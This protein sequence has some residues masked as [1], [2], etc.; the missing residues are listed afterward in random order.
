MK[1]PILLCSLLILGLLETAS[2]QDVDLDRPMSAKMVAPADRT[3]HQ[4]NTSPT[5]D[6][7][8]ILLP[9]GPLLV[10]TEISINDRHHQ[11]IWNELLAELYRT[12]DTN[13]DG[14]VTWEEA[15][16]NPRFADGRL[17][18]F[19]Q[20]ED[21]RQRVVR[22]YDRNNN[23]KVDREEL[24]F[25]IGGQTGFT[26]NGSGRS[27]NAQPEL[28]EL[29]DTNQDGKLSA[30][31]LSRAAARLLS[32]DRNDNQI[33][34]LYELVSSRRTARRGQPAATSIR[35]TPSETDWSNVCKMLIQR[36]SQ[37]EG[38][39]STSHFRRSP[40]LA[41]HLDQN[42]NQKLE[43]SELFALATVEPHLVLGIRFSDQSA[44]SVEIVSTSSELADVWKR[45][46]H[47]EEGISIFLGDCQLDI[48]A[49]DR[50]VAI[51][52]NYTRQAEQIIQRFDKDKNQYLER[53][54]LDS[55]NASYYASQ[56]AAW[57]TDNDGK[58]FTEELEAAFHRS[59]QYTLARIQGTS[60]QEGRN[61]FATL[62][63]SGDQRLTL[64]ELYE[65]AEFLLEFD[66]NHDAQ[67]E[68]SEVPTRYR[69][70]F[71]RGGTPISMN[72][73]QQAI[74]SQ[75]SPNGEESSAAPKWFVHADRNGD[76]AISP[77]EFLGTEAQFH[78]LD[79][80]QDG[81]IDASEAS[82]PKLADANR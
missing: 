55:R 12:G 75:R 58:V 60:F 7:F 19:G 65:I 74:L 71:G 35:L 68:T 63:R 27:P 31:E 14:T 48:V 51:R 17:A 67:I 53:D 81:F 8:L 10:E 30:Q 18:R 46:E 38:G 76:G 3:N 37:T 47:T 42:G 50:A 44:P 72:R 73:Y 54:E 41:Q 32:R 62:D 66:R 69:F 80:N 22:S 56:F 11:Q 39:L 57:D 82:S 4:P 25:L 33:V 45:I 2:A 78:N 36:Y 49:A 24:R 52:G 9:R 23:G 43:E 70:G 59:S 79:R 64:R 61:L 34:E 77:R 20:R 5:R 13:Q 16:N 28:L 21:G 1:A 26:F 15:F 6:R 40:A 29:L